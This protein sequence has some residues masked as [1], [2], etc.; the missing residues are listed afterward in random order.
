V[1]I[2]PAIVLLRAPTFAGPGRRVRLAGTV[3]PRKRRVWQLIER[4]RR[5]RFVRISLVRLR[6]QE[7][8]FS[9]S[10]TPL[11]TGL[12]R[13]TFVTRRDRATARGRSRPLLIAVR[14][15][16]GGAPAP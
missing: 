5:G 6:V 9:S 7:G 1:R 16:A 3:K 4:R 10:F 15:S 11:R 13:V 14:L 12:F 2:R 8:R